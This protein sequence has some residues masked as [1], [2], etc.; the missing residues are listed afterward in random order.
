MTIWGVIIGGAAGFA[1]GGPIGALLGIAAGHFAGKKLRQKLDPE[2]SKKV[3]FSVAVIALSAKMAKADGVVSRK[4]IESFRARV[5]I[6][7][8]DVER[9]GRFWDLARQTPDGF[10]AY[11]RQTVKLFGPRSA[12]LEQLLDL[13]FSIAKA[14]GEISIREW[15][16][17]REVADIFGYDEPQFN[18]LCDIYAGLN[19]APH[20][21]LGVAADATIDEVRAAWKRLA[22][23]HHPDRLISSG[24]PEEFVKAATSRLAEINSAYESLAGQ[25]RDRTA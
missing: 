6:P 16:Y 2:Q 1:L 22:K 12:I 9:V 14:D 4:E 7:A 3:A 5:D 24:M 15:A 23:K 21:V 8:G 19:A 13:L 18:R 25:I 11:A 10:A 17:L 20:L